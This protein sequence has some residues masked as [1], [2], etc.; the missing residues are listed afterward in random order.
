MGFANG[1]TPYSSSVIVYFDRALEALEIVFYVNGAAVEG[2]A[3]RN[4]HKM[5]EIG[6]GES[7]SWGS[8][9]TKREGCECELTKNMFLYRKKL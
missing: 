7:V 6:E 8:A 1:R 9:Q 5:K 3:D 2:M 4:C